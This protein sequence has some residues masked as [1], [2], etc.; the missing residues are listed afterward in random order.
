MKNHQLIISIEN[1]ELDFL[2]KCTAPNHAECVY[3]FCSLCQKHSDKESLE[4]DSPC[5]AT[6]QEHYIFRGC[7]YETDTDLLNNLIDNYRCE[8]AV[9]F[10]IPTLTSE[11]SISRD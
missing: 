4:N 10:E 11:I 5:L 3:Y 8:L 7:E 9:D 1:R 2:I 6:G